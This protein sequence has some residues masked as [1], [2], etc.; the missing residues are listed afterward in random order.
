MRRFFIVLATVVAMAVAVLPAVADAATVASKD[1]RVIYTAGP[2]ETNALTVAASASA[3]VLSDPNALIT[4]G[5]GCKAAAP[6]HQVTCPRGGVT[7]IQAEL[8]DRGDAVAVKPSVSESVLARGGDGDDLLRGGAA[9]DELLGAA[10]KDTLDGGPG[11]VADQLS[12]GGGTD[13]VDYSARTKGVVVILSGTAGDGEA[14]E[15]DSVGPDV[16][17][18]LGG[19]GDD[20]L[21]GTGGPNALAGH[22]GDDSLQADKGADTLNGGG[23][24]DQVLYTGR[25]NPVTVTLDGVAND[26]APGENDAIVDV[27]DVAGGSGADTLVGNGSDNELIGA[28]GNDTLRGLG[29]DDRVLGNAGTDVLDGGAGA[30]DATSYATASSGVN[31]SLDGVANDGQPGEGDQA[32]PSVENVSGSDFGDR[33]IGNDGGNRF[34]GGIGNDALEGKGGD[35]VLVG[36]DGEDTLIGE[37]GDDHL[38]GLGG[39][40]TASYAERTTPVVATINGTGGSGAERDIIGSTVEKVTG[41]DGD[42]TLTGTDGSDDV[43]FGGRGNDHLI[44]LAGADGLDAGLGFDFLEGGPDPDSLRARD[45]ELDLIACDALDTL[46][47]DSIDIKGGC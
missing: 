19:S 31:V 26:G 44:G 45:G 27:Q 41:G 32:D 22:G 43:L 4:P 2:G 12:G 34:F 23:G 29:G 16:E 8:R 3:V 38:V 40:D 17:N 18:A 11:A 30:Q 33:L 36:D 5:V 15:Q 46:D 35:D 42:D 13:T 6:S 24:R 47:I 25:T 7:E 14:G 21:S 37:A 10:G 39:F 9:S 1:G 20:R 28:P